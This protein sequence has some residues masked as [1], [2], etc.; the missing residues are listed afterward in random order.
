MD[1]VLRCSRYAFGPNRFHYCGPD[2]NREIFNYI[3]E[4]VSDPR[5]ENILKSFQSMY[6]YL[7]LIAHSNSIKDPFDERVVEAYWLGN[8]FLER[9][10]GKQLFRHIEEEQKQRLSQQ[11]FQQVTDK[12]RQGALPH[13]S[14]HI[15]DVW[16]QTSNFKDDHDL[17]SLDSC[18]ISAGKIIK[19]D[20]PFLEVETDE[21]VMRDGKL[22][23]NGPIKKKINRT[24]SANIDL[25]ELEVADIISLHWGEVCEKINEAQAKNLQKYTLGSLVLANQTI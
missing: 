6:P 18:R 15:L 10:R 8:E 23:L 22:V 5:L 7:K 13:H 3:D 21:L 12:I 2:A 16:T 14:F 24:F 9:A 11:S 25:E 4:K 19:L 17:E 1:G 20:G